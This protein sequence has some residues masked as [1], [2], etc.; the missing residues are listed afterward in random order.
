MNLKFAQKHQSESQLDGAQWSCHETSKREI[1]VAGIGSAV[2]CI[3]TDRIVGI[4]TLVSPRFYRHVCIAVWAMITAACGVCKT[5]Q[6]IE[7]HG[8]TQGA[9]G[10]L[11]CSLNTVHVGLTRTT[12]SKKHRKESRSSIGYQAG[13]PALSYSRGCHDCVQ[14]ETVKRVKL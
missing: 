9:H 11:K 3:D 6:I 14:N 1:R 8:G 13:I 4:T 5:P 7:R 12:N 2:C 10:A